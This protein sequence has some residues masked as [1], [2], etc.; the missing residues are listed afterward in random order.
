MNAIRQADVLM[1][2]TCPLVIFPEGEVYHVNDRVMLFRGPGRDCPDG[3]QKAAARWSASL[4]PS[5][6]ATSKTRRPN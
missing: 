1:S 3:R 4:V 2:G 6:I 5:S